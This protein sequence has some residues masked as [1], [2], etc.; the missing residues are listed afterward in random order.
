MPIVHFFW[1]LTGYD[2]VQLIPRWVGR[3]YYLLLLIPTCSILLLFSLFM[4]FPK[5]VSLLLLAL[6]DFS[7]VF[8]V[9]AIIRTA[10]HAKGDFSLIILPGYY[11]IIAGIIVLNITA[12]NSSRDTHN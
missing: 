2:V 3:E 1:T 8:S 12:I 5:K 10:I 7:F 11:L 4:F 6:L 9:Y